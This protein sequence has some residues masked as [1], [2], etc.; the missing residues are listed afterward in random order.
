M[1]ANSNFHHLRD[2]IYDLIEWHYVLVELVMRLAQHVRNPNRRP[3]DE[4]VHWSHW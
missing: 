3:F 4:V 2:T 1:I